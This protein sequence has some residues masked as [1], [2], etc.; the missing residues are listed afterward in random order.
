MNN[1]DHI[2][3]MSADLVERYPM[4]LTVT[5]PKC[6]NR[7]GMEKQKSVL[8]KMMKHMFDNYAQDAT[9]AFEFTLKGNV[10]A[11]CFF[12]PR[13]LFEDDV[14]VKLEIV[15]KILSSIFKKYSICDLQIIKDHQH[16]YNYITKDNEIMRKI[17]NKPCFSYHRESHVDKRTIEQKLGLT[18]SMDVHKMEEI[19]AQCNCDCTC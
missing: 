7:K 13:Q 11:H 10:H 9:G 18:C 19:D 14:Q 15:V 12:N 5:L 16:V 4:F 2:E 8:L 17:M 1:L 3:S 6:H